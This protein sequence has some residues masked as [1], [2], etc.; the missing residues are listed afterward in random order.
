MARSSKSV[1]FCAI[2]LALSVSCGEETSTQPQPSPQEAFGDQNFA[3]EAFSIEQGKEKL[4]CYAKTLD[5]DLV[6][7]GFDFQPQP[8]VHHLL[9]V[10]AQAKEPEG[11]SD[12]NVLFRPT[13]RPLFTATT[14]PTRLEMPTGTGLKLKKGDQLVL[15]LHLLNATSSEGTSKVD[16]RMRTAPSNEVEP[17]GVFVFGR[18]DFELPPKKTTEVVSDCTIS[19]DISVFAA[20]PHMHYLGRKLSFE[21]DAAGTMEERFRRDPYTF[22]DQRLEPWEAKLR[23]G[24]KTRT[25]C[26]FENTQT[27]TARFGESSL[28]EM[29]FF[30]AFVRGQSG[31]DVCMGDGN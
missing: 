1:I 21:V 3:T 13:W 28:D 31:L 12:C 23:A 15:Q 26:F 6:I 17:V 8:L 19:K 22:D 16:I 14:A 24:T 30:V 9:F 18:S 25:R 29:C 11:F 2:T 20:G 5:Q 7:D 4:L 27:E 10:H